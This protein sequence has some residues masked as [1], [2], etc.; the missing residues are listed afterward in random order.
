VRLPGARRGENRE[1]A[2]REGI[3][4]PQELMTKIRAL[5]GEESH[6]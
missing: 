6:A 3:R 5:A 1:R 4:I 2:A